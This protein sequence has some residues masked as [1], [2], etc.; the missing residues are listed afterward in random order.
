[1]KVPKFLKTVIALL[2]C[3]AFIRAVNQAGTVDLD[4]VI[5]KIQSFEFDFEGVQ[6]VIDYFVDGKILESI[7]PWDSSLTGVGGFFQNVGNAIVGYIQVL[8]NALLV[9]LYGL[10]LL[11]IE[12]VLLIAQ[13]IEIITYI[14]GFTS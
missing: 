8:I 10:I 2:V 14:C 4:Q 5:L 11:V 1:M 13:L 6:T 3:I 7:K 12:V 9:P